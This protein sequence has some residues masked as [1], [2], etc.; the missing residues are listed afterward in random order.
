MHGADALGTG[1]GKHGADA[2]G[3]QHGRHGVL[4]DYVV[5]VYFFLSFRVALML[6]WFCSW[7][8]PLESF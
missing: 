7:M 5:P 2:L 4:G 1:H 8:I 3:T 6:A